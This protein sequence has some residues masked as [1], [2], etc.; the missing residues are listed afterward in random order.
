VTSRTDHSWDVADDEDE[1]ETGRGW[2]A[3][4]VVVALVGVGSGSAFVWHAAGG[5]LQALVP[6]SPTPVVAAV[7]AKSLEQDEVNALRQQIVTLNQS[8]QQLL[9]GRQAE[10][11]RLTDQVAALSS[12]LDLLQRPVTSPQA[13]IPSARSTAAAPAPAPAK[14]KQEA[15]KS[16]ATRSV[17]TAR[18]EP[19]PVD[20]RPTGAISTGGAPLPLIR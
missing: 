15:A 16:E 3:R 1:A 5:S 14:K 19:K 17:A 2:L 7:T 9:A 4:I 18:P 20:T 10:I 6:R 11:K 12:K 13:A 8:S